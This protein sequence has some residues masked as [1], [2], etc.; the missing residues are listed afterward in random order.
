MKRCIV[1][2]LLLSLASAQSLHQHINVSYDGGLWQ[3]EQL[4]SCMMLTGRA[5]TAGGKDYGD[6]KKLSCTSTLKSSHMISD[7]TV[8]LDSEAEAV[9]KQPN[10]WAIRLDCTRTRRTQID[11]IYAGD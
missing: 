4:K 10:H 3:L 2:P 9:F 7:A 1:I 5:I 11:C 8:S 6:P